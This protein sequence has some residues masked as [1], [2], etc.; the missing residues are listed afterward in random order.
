[1]QRILRA[2]RTGSARRTAWL[3]AIG[4]GLTAQVA[5]SGF[6]ITWLGKDSDWQAAAVRLLG[7]ELAAALFGV[8]A[9][10]HALRWMPRSRGVT[11][12][13]PLVYLS[14]VSYMAIVALSEDSYRAAQFATVYEYSSPADVAVAPNGDVYV[15]DWYQADVKIVDA[16]TGRVTAP[17]LHHANA[18]LF[19]GLAMPRSMALY[20]DGSL[21]VADTGN[22]VLR[23][24]D[25]R[26]GTLTR[27]AG[28]GERGFSGDGGPATEADLSG[29]R[30]VAVDDLGNVFFADRGNR[31]IRR[32]DAATSVITTVA[33]NGELASAGDGGPALEASLVIPMS[34]AVDYEGNLYVL[35]RGSNRVRRIDPKTGI[36]TAYAGIEE[37]GFSG[38]GGP[39]THAQLWA[40]QGIALDADGNLYIADR[41]NHRIRRVE[42]ATGAIETFAGTGVIGTFGGDYGGDGGLATEAFLN[43]PVA[44]SVDTA[45]NVLIAD[46][47]NHLVRRVDAATGIMETVTAKRRRKE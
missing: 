31:R 5:V 8:A 23:R 4:T 18:G 17:T 12:M 11:L 26:S 10:L 27:F 24:L 28:S 40:P 16:V 30:G 15:L 44:V 36:I 32:V 37:P 46:A 34:V 20:G 25:P 43:S 13:V 45:G 38:D 21:I 29:P 22:N 33:G 6:V 7:G 42:A 14:A 1:M 3:A 47:G 9:L 19:R 39:A 35:D 41:L 2:K